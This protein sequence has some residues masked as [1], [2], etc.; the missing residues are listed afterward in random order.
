[1][2]YFTKIK[3]ILSSKNEIKLRRAG[4]FIAAKDV[5]C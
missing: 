4:V 1:M 3:E 5:F 2:A